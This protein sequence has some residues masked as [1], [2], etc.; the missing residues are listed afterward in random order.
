MAKRRN[1]LLGSQWE[2]WQAAS[3][4]TGQ[5]ASWQVSR[6]V[7]AMSLPGLSEQYPRNRPKTQV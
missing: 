7:H 4:L 3:Q 5:G 2:Q 6:E 1:G